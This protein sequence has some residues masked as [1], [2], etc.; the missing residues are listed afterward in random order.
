MSLPISAHPTYFGIVGVNITTLLV[1]VA[2]LLIAI[3]LRAAHRKTRLFDVALL[4][5][6]LS[7][8]FLTLHGRLLQPIFPIALPEQPAFDNGLTLNYFFTNLLTYAVIPLLAIAL[9]NRQKPTATD[10]GLKVSDRKR[11]AAYTVMG[12]AFASAIY[13]L[14]NLFFHQQ[15]VTNYTS[16]GLA[17]W[18]VLVSVVSV[19]LQTLFFVSLLFYRYLGKEN[20][21]LIAIIAVLT[22]QSFVGPN[23]IVWQLCSIITFS[24]KLFVTWKT[25][26]VYGAIIIAVTVSLIELTLQIL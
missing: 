1:A 5:F 21:V 22:A 2:A 13:L 6:L 23:F 12:A 19:M 18:L 25:R 24:T 11:T 8:V 20:T 10:L 3:A 16:G 15:W 14:T 4:V 9:V 26:N 17:L 7:F